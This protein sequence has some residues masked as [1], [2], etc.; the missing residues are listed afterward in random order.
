MIQ[1]EVYYINFKR[2]GS[3]KIVVNAIAKCTRAPKDGDSLY[4]G[5]GAELETILPLSGHTLLDNEVITC[6]NYD[7][8]KDLNNGSGLLIT[9]KKVNKDKYPEYFL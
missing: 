1:G 4:S 2:Q 5:F 8:C 9:V 7:E 6:R 3:D